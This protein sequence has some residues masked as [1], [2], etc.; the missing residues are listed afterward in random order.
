MVR[1]GVLGV[2][3]AGLALAGCASAPVSERIPHAESRA[4]ARQTPM[5]SAP[6]SDDLWL[7]IRAG[8]ALPAVADRPEIREWTHFYATHRDHLLGAAERAR[9]FLWHIVEALEAR[10]MPMELALL[11]IVESGFDPSARSYAGASGLWQ[12]IPVTAS[13]FG[14]ERNWWYDARLDSLSA[15]DAALDYLGWL[16]AE[17]D[18]WLLALAAYNCGEGCVGRALARAGAR[19][20]PQTFWTIDLPAQT[21]NY[22]PKLLALKRILSDPEAYALD[23]PSL[24]NRPLTATVAL[25]GQVE[26]AVAAEMIGMS[27]TA[28]R[29]INPA[30]RRWATH[31][32]SP[33]ALLVPVQYADQLRT[34]LAQADPDELVTWRRHRVARGEVLGAIA[35]TYGTSVSM[36]QQVNHLGSTLIHPG[37]SLL[38][39]TGDAQAVPV[40][41]PALARANQPL[42]R[43]QVAR[44]E[45]LW[46]IAQ[47]YGVGVAQLRRWNQ[48]S[49]SLLRPGEELLVRGAAPPAPVKHYVVEAGDSLWGIARAF[50][51]HVAELRSWNALPQGAVLQPGQRLEI[52]SQGLVVYRVRDGDSL[53]AIASRFAVDIA[54]LRAWNDLAGGGYIHPGQHLRIVIGST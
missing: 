42:L 45:T 49:D 25:P 16:H 48:L 44:G 52:R 50:N 15:T 1:P 38:I 2:L 12:F 43:H 8:F 30:F 51:V 9:P 17:F 34:A 33:H 19:G 31:P 11:P 26:L 47:H 13:R 3:A 40:P 39:P 14:L 23:W 22:V 37:D 29:A 54:D 36:I 46:G 28:L 10:G 21:D 5:V 18:N 24:A 7:R 6:S 27:A 32:D 35:Q 4:P 53:W 41:P 20:R